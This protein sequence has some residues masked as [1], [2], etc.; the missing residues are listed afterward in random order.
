MAGSKVAK[1]HSKIKRLAKIFDSDELKKLTDSIEAIVGFQDVSKVNK[2]LKPARVGR[3]VIKAVDTVNTYVG[4]Y[5][6][7]EN[8][9]E[10]VTEYTTAY[11]EEFIALTSQEISDDLDRRYEPLTSTFF[12]CQWAMIQFAELAEANNWDIA[13]NALTALD[14]VDPTGVVGAFP[15]GFMTIFVFSTPSSKYL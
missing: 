15:G 10:A 2:K 9:Y 7:D 1:T 8:F 3:K 6:N 5:G 14:L 4:W 11:A 12:K 13:Y